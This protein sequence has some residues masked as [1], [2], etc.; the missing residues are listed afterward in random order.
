MS[1]HDAAP[2]RVVVFSALDNLVKG[3]AGPGHPEPEPGP[4]LGRGAGPADGARTP[5]RRSD[6][7]MTARGVYKVGGPAL[8]DP[9]SARPS[10]RGDQRAPGP[11]LLVHGGGRHVERVLKALG[12]ESRVRGRAPRDV[13]GGHGGGRDGPLGDREQGAGRGPHRRGPARRSGSRAATPASCARA[14]AA[15]ARPRRARPEVGEPAP[16]LGALWAAGFVPV[17]SPVSAGPVGRGRQ[18]QRR[19][20][21]PRPRRA[22]CGARGLVYLSDVDGVRLGGE[23][24]PSA[25]PRTR[26]RGRIADGTIAGGMASRSGWRSSAAAAGIP[27]VVVAGKARLI[28]GFAGTRIAGRGAE[29]GAGM[30]AL[31]PVYE[32][33]LVLVSGKG[34][35]LFDKRRPE[36]TSTSRRASR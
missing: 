8:E 17:V 32:R 20:G 30:S 36:P 16:I 5:A 4:R 14:L 34:A 22:P 18:R 35:R 23:T 15:G 12:L 2:G 28:G 11:V 24:R 10:G 9:G 1:V 27:E 21:G 7:P 31:L 3:A 13:A 33:D 19:R 29:R 6:E 25:R 26:P